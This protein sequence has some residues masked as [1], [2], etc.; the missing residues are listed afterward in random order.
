ML[1]HEEQPGRAPFV[2]FP[3]GRKASIGEDPLLAAQRE[4]LEETGYWIELLDR[5]ETLPTPVLEPLQQST[6]EIIRMMVSS[7]NTV[8]R[9]IP[10]KPSSKA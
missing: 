6:D 3:G 7:I 5:S 1:I 10:A 8:N 4:F 2:T 9:S